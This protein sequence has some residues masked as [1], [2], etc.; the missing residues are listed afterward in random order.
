MIVTGRKSLG[1]QYFLPRR[2]AHQG[3]DIGPKIRMSIQRIQQGFGRSRQSRDWRS[4]NLRMQR[5][6]HV[7]SKPRVG[8]GVVIGKN[9][10]LVAG[11][12]VGEDDFLPYPIHGLVHELHYAILLCQ[13]ERH[14]VAIDELGAFGTISCRG[15]QLSPIDP[16]RQRRKSF[17]SIFW[18]IGTLLLGFLEAIVEHL[19][20]YRNF[21]RQKLEMEHEL[22]ALWT[23]EQ[24]DGLRTIFTAD[25]CVSSVLRDW[26]C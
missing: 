14:R 22:L 9:Y 3:H 25:A 8:V 2:V 5:S 20:E 18:K 4:R 6:R 26:Y 23:N 21:G 10:K 17:R 1:F 13:A 16:A 11:T 7:Q 24:A 15:W 19:I 12:A